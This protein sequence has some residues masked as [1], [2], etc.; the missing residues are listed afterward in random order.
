[1]KSDIFL[2]TALEEAFKVD[3]NKKIGSV[4]VYRNKIISKG[5]NYINFNNITN[6]D[7]FLYSTHSEMDC[8]KKCKNIN[9]YKNQ[10]IMYIVRIDNNQNIANVFPC[11]NCKK[12]LIKHNIKWVCYENANTEN[13]FRINNN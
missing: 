11:D 1:M 4:L 7:V 3:M 9:R 5:H 10:L 13:Y 6:K 12:I 2:E 8:I